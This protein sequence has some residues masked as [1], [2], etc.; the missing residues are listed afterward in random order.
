MNKKPKIYID[1]TIL[2]QVNFLTG[3]QRVIIEILVR[4]LKRGDVDVVMLQY[5]SENEYFRILDNNAFLLF[6]EQKTGSKAE[7]VLNKIMEK[8]EFEPGSVFF[9]IDGVWNCRLTRSSF[10]PILKKQGVKIVTHVYDIIPITHPQ[11][12]HENTVMH[13]IEYLGASL[14]LS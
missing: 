6:Y 11:Y 8:N 9:D 5:S 3:I 2:M 7:C 4:L 13:F 1:L 14:S 10:Y 12:C